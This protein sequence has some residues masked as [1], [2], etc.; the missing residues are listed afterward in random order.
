MLRQ[1]HFIFHLI[2]IFS[3]E[4]MGRIGGMKNCTLD[5]NLH[6][7]I[8]YTNLGEVID[9]SMKIRIGQIP[10]SGDKASWEI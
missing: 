2:A 7:E 3:H 9:K 1:G 5:I 10:I 8:R 4:G 6:Q